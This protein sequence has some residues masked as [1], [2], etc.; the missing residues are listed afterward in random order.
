[1]RDRAIISP[2]EVVGD[3]MLGL[4][5]D[6]CTIAD[7][8]V[9]LLRLAPPAIT[10]EELDNRW[11]PPWPKPLAYYLDMFQNNSFPVTGTA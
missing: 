3:E 9:E 11:C 2:D 7:I 5:T 10:F 4:V 1:M 6:N 8:E